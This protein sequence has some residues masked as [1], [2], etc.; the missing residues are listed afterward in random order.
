MDDGEA[1]SHSTWASLEAGSSA[2]IERRLTP[3]GRTG[4]PPE[5]GLMPER[6]TPP[7]RTTEEDRVL[8]QIGHPRGTLAIVVIYAALFALGWLG[9]YVARFLERGAPRP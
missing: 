6:V 5:G 4:R 8:A 7:P 1:P 9:M 3:A 2:E